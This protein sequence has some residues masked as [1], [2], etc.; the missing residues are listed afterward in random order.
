MSGGGS[1]PGYQGEFTVGGIS[2]TIPYV[3]PS[4]PFTQELLDLS[5]CVAILQMASVI[6]NSDM[7]TLIHSAAS[8]AL[9]LGSQQLARDTAAAGS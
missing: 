4:V 9:A 7:R 2:V 6:N 5:L 3:D 1:G 8:K